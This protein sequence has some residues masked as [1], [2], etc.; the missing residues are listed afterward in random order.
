[1]TADLDPHDIDEVR[2]RVVIP[3]VTSL[4][5][6]SELEEITVE[7]RPPESPFPYA[8]LTVSLKVCGEW[9]SVSARWAV[10]EDDLWDAER[11]ARDLYDRL[12]DEL[13][14]SSFAWAQLRD[15]EYEVLGPLPD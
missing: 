4:V 12:R 6:Q 9:V 15:G 1:M 3:V 2:R 14:E 11:F 8:G 13:T 10:L 7:R 5:Q